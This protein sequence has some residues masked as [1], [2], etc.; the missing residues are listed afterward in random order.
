MN[1]V[2][3]PSQLDGTVQAIPSKSDVHRKLIC[4]A[5][6][7]NGGFLPIKEPYCDDIA[8]TVRCLSALGASFEQN[9]DGLFI[10]PIKRKAHALLDCGESGSTL[11][12]L[13]P[14]AM[15]VCSSIHVTGAG[16]LPVCAAVPLAVAVTAGCELLFLYVVYPEVYT[17]TAGYHSDRLHGGASDGA[18]DRRWATATVV[19]GGECGVDLSGAFYF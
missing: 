4:A 19:L 9:A 12:F 8:A 3:C 11:R 18:L 5:I 6:S 16:R 13:L 14:V 15:C 2:C 10:R 1:A 17:D 7:E